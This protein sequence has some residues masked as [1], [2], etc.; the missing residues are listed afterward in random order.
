MWDALSDERTCMPF[1]RLSAIISLLLVCKIYIL[2]FIKNMYVQHI[3]AYKT[4]TSS[5]S[6]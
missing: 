5:G 3:R 4:S 6:V 1:A 2:Q